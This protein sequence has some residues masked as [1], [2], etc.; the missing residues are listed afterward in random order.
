MSKIR[1]LIQQIRFSLS[2]L[3]AQNRHYDFEDICRHFSRNRL[4][5]NILPATGPVSTG[6]DQGRD[7][8]TYEILPEIISQSKNR[9]ISGSAAFACTTQ[10]N[11]ILKK[12][13]DDVQKII[14]KGNKVDIIYF[15]SL[16][17]VEVSRRHRVQKWS[18]LTE[19]S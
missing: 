17:N 15:F 13:K 2:N 19:N 3:G 10:K 14:E 16:E 5:L 9:L 7:F 12:I 6:G 1:S 4:G 11:S 18:L 8:E